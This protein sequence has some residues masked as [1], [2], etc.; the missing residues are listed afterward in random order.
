[1][2]KFQ[3]L[4]CGA[5]GLSIWMRTTVGDK[6]YSVLMDGGPEGLSMERNV[7]AMKVPLDQL[8]AIVLSHWHSDHSGGIL[9]ALSLRENLS[10]S[11]LP[12]VKVDLHPDRPLRRGIA[13][14]PQW[15]PIVALEADPSLEEIEQHNGKVDLHDEAHEIQTSSGELTGVGVSGKIERVT[16]FEKGIPGAVR[17]RE[18]EDGVLPITGKGSWFSDELIMDERYVVVDVKGKGL[19]IFSSCS[20]AGICNV[21]TDAMAKYSRPIYMVAGGLHLVPVAQQP[22][23]QTVDFLARRV[24]P[25]PK[26]VLP[27][28]CTGLEPRGRIRTAMGDAC[29]PAGVGMRVVVEGDESGDAQLASLKLGVID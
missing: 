15:I 9:K 18:E 21:L 17:W 11:P 14:P 29:V 5:H 27:L 7:H 4:C 22:V 6:S 2:M 8:D 23:T 25:T 24:Q 26:F 20:H 1:V 28:H 19:V 16:P 13:P 10:S 12:P 3:N